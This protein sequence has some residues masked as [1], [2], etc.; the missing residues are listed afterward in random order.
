MGARW[1]ACERG[2]GLII[3]RSCG[4][5]AIMRVPDEILD[6]YLTNLSILYLLKLA[7]H[8]AAGQTLQ[9]LVLPPSL[10]VGHGRLPEAF[11]FGDYLGS[12]GF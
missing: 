10:L 8:L 7:E 2:L 3:D 4:S 6:F 9:Q 11:V 1:R 5:L 12:F